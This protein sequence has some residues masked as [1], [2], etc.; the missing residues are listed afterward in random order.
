MA[1]PSLKRTVGGLHVPPTRR[2]KFETL[3]LD[4][5][6]PSP[7][8]PIFRAK[9]A[10]YKGIDSVDQLIADRSNDR[11]ENGKIRNDLIE[12]IFDCCVHEWGTWSEAGEAT[13]LY[14]DDSGEVVD[15]TLENFTY[16][17]RECEGGEELLFEIIG[18]FQ[19]AAWFKI[20]QA[21]EEK[22]FL[23]PSRR[24]SAPATS[25]STPRGRKR[26]R[27]AKPQK[28]PSDRQAASA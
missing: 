12:I 19:Q 15:C 6:Y 24:V 22:N 2:A 23:R 3:W 25:S 10:K 17:V 5:L 1:K 26:G 9:T 8:N 28:Q 18:R 20:Q 27:A 14:D 13:P 7:A 11:D 4:L 21:A 16:V